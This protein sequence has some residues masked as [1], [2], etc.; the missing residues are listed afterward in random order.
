MRTYNPQSCHKIF[1]RMISRIVTFILTFDLYVMLW[2]LNNLGS[3]SIKPG[4]KVFLELYQAM[5]H[6]FWPL[7]Y[8]CTSHSAAFV[9]FN[10]KN[11]STLTSKSILFKQNRTSMARTPLEPWKY[12]PDMGTCQWLGLMAVNHSARSR[13]II[14]ISF[15]FSFI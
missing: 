5:L 9:Q 11:T 1:P 3:S 13:G 14:G 4:T 10:I 7:T 2:W 8:T 12:F 6:L 15:R